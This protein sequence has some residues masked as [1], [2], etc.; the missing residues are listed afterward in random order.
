MRLSARLNTIAA[1]V[2]V[3]ARIADIGTDHAYLPVYLV[4]QGVVS[5][6]LATDIAEGPCRAAALQVA[7][8]GLSEKIAVRRGDGL[9]AIVS[10]EADTVIIAGLGG[11][12]IIKILD[13][14]PVVLSSLDALILQPM[15]AARLLRNWLLA[16]KWRLVREELAA[17]REKLYEIILAKPN[18]N[19]EQPS[20][21]E[22]EL[23]T[24]PL[25]L[26]GGHPLLANKVALTA[27]KYRRLCHNMEKSPRPANCNKYLTAKAIL[28]AAEE[29]LKCP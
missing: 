28:N 6:A 29:Y 24:G 18:K 11:A 15:S 9:A 8:A 14:Q 21:T 22:F 19:K 10:G 7:G 20:Y 16:N 1:L 27:A 13:S 26:T 2:P 3:G 12:S 17:E 23:E 4:K 25:L 5:S